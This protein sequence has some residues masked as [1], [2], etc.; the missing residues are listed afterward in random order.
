MGAFKGW[1]AC[2]G[3]PFMIAIL[4]F[5]YPVFFAAVRRSCRTFKVKGVIHSC[6]S[7]VMPFVAAHANINSVKLQACSLVNRLL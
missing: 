7:I 5:F 3:L 6:I 4:H 1:L 2:N